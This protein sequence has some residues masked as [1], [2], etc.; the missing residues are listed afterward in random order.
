MPSSS[1][2]PA[3]AGRTGTAAS[4]TII[5][6]ADA[7]ASSF[8]TDATPPRVASR[9]QRTGSGRVQQRVDGGPQRS[10]V[11]LDL[12]VQVE[13]AARQ[14]DRRA[15]LADA[16]RQQDAVTRAQTGRRELR[17]RIAAADAGGAHVHAVGVATLDHLG[18]AGDHLHAGR[19]RGCGRSPRPRRAARRPAGP[20]RAPATGQRERPSAGDGQVVD[21]AVDGQLAD[22][23][24]GE[25]QRPDHVGVG[26]QGQ[27]D[28]VHRELA[29]V[30]QPAQR[31]RRR[32]P[33][34]TGPRSASGSPC[35]RRRGPS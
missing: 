34:R 15:V 12:G 20:P 16:S 29:G 31:R 17:P 6:T 28:A 4:R 14:H 5:A 13:L 27:P 18:V 2:A 24:A 25:P 11:R 35:R 7:R 10:R 23:P 26:G 8:S 22:R 9:M 1:A 30:G 19:L 3:T 21:G 32:R 33:G